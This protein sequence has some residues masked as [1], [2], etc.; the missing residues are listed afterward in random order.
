MYSSFMGKGSPQEWCSFPLFQARP[1]HLARNPGGCQHSKHLGRTCCL[2]L[3]PG[4]VWFAVP[5]VNLVERTLNC[6]KRQG[7][8]GRARREANSEGHAAGFLGFRV[9]DFIV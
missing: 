9:E 2:G 7:R 8:W 3:D 6:L 4:V 1:S 5:F